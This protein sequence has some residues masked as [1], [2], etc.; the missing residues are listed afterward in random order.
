MWRAKE[1]RGQLVGKRQKRMHD[2]ARD[3][4]RFACSFTGMA[5]VTRARATMCVTVGAVMLAADGSAGCGSSS[6]G[7]VVA[8]VG[9]VSIGKDAVDHWAQAIRKG[10]LLGG[11]G[12]GL[13]G[14]PRDRALS[15]LISSAWLAGEAKREGIAITD[16]S[17]ERAVAERRD[18]N[19][20]QSFKEGLSATGQTVDDVR[21]EVRVEIETAALRRNLA[22]SMAPVA[23]ADVVGFYRSSPQLF[24]IPEKRI[25]DLIERL[26]SPAAAESLVARIGVG[27]RFARMA[28]HETLTR[29]ANEMSGNYEKALLIRAIFAARRGVLSVP[30]RLSRD[31]TVFVVRKIMPA[32]IKPLAAVRREVVSRL[33]GIRRRRL[34]IV[35]DAE[36]DARWSARTSCRAG[37]AVQGCAQYRGAG[38]D[39]RGGP[40]SG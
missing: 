26:P 18:A 37:Y 2:P 3:E 39:E 14:S 36:Y 30:M 6:Q 22:H 13:R 4:R 23:Q 31:W 33:T 11:H 32:L 28:Y 29:N 1:S 24:R 34:A 12:E 15:F 8:R 27:E 17:V 20:D 19:G 9:A 38:V 16:G 10:G 40:F 35:R 21:L 25:V 7:P 5:R